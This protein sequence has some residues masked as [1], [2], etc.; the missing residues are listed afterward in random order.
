M[1]EEPPLDAIT[2]ISIKGFKSFLEEQRIEIWPL[3][4]LAGANSSGKSSALQ[5]LLLLKQTLESPVDTGPLELAGPHVEFTSPRQF[6]AKH[7]DGSLVDRFEISVALLK[8]PRFR[9]FFQ[10]TAD[11]RIDLIRMEH[12]FVSAGLPTSLILEPGLSTEDLMNRLPTWLEGA[13]GRVVRARCFLG[14]APEGL[15]AP[16]FP[17]LSPLARPILS[18]I[19]V[20]GLR[21]P[22]RTHRLTA[23]EEAFQGVFD[24]YAASSVAEWQKTRDGRLKTLESQLAELGLTSAVQVRRIDATRLEL[25]VGRS[26]AGKGPEDL[27]S[28]AD[29]GFGVSQVLPVLVALLVAKPGQLVYLEQPELHLHPRA[30]QALATVLADAAIRGVRV[31]AETHSS[32]LLLAVQTLVAEGKLSQDLVKLHW[33]QRDDRG[34]TKVT[35]ADLDQLGAYGDWPQDFGE[36]ESTA[37]N[38]YLDAVESKA[39]PRKKRAKK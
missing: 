4:L 16:V 13:P 11:D 19:H 7:A 33:F 27:V 10:R 32:I 31:V 23:T 34:A 22:A 17:M 28:L 15:G 12:F 21:T 37:D 2:A 18:V 26:V 1:A 30:Q 35:S 14:V 20:S 5:P 36:I 25:L 8:R 6:M 38:R 24:P 29:V 39:F 3:T 9:G